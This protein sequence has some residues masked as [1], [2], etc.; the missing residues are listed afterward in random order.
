MTRL[1]WLLI[2]PLC[3]LAALTGLIW[4]SLAAMH[5]PRGKR[6]WSLAE[7][8]DRLANAAIGGL[9]EMTISAHAGQQI[10]QPWAKSLCWLLNLVD[11][12]HC[13]KS[14]D[15]YQNHGK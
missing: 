8:F 15:A 12:N 6:A 1:A 11:P 9:D 10:H 14:W 7:G 13:Q 5:D 4:L 3:A 2:I